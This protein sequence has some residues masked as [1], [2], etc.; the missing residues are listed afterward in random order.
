M[1]ARALDVST[2]GA[3]Q[4]HVPIGAGCGLCIPYMQR[5]LAG[6]ET[7]LPV[8]SEAEAERWME[9]SGVRLLGEE[10]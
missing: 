3:L 6:G 7:R 10:E 1:L 4:H 9:C 5:A 8:L 2:V